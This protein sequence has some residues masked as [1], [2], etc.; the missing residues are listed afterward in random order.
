MRPLV[1]PDLL[2][3]GLSAAR[4]RNRRPSYRGVTFQPLNGWM[5]KTLY[6]GLAQGLPTILPLGDLYGEHERPHQPGFGRWLASL[7]AIYSLDRMV[8]LDLPWW[9]IA[10]TEAV[11]EFLRARPSATVFEYGSGASSLWLA[12]RAKSVITV[13]HDADWAAKVGAKL[14]G[15]ANARL[16][17]VPGLPGG[18]AP[19]HSQ[20]TDHPYVRAIASQGLF[21]LIVI[22]GRQRT[23]CLEAALPHL[24]PGGII[25]FD[26]S[27][28]KRYRKS[29]ETCGLVE[30]HFFGRSYCVPYSDHTSILSHPSDTGKD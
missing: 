19:G 30:R 24:K 1:D 3:V 17:S 25:L 18:Q 11:E 28:R 16:I 5:L 20:A 2:D 21:N 12:R 13:E 15:H 22:D 29:I 4:R 27:G 6:V 26:D 9:N 10:A 8:A 14:G 7:G 23:R